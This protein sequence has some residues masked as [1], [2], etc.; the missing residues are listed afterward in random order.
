[1]CVLAGERARVVSIVTEGLFSNAFSDARANFTISSNIR[2]IIRDQKKI[3]KKGD[4][5]D[6]VACSSCCLKFSSPFNQFAHVICVESVGLSI[7]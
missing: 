3:I 1:V 2:I 7:P 5:L 4:R 6:R